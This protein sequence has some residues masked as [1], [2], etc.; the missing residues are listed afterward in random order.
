MVE[1]CDG[2]QTVSLIAFGVR[3]DEASGHGFTVDV[4]PSSIIDDG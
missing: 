3:R 2:L 1:I 4:L